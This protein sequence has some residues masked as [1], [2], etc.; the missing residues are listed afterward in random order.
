M[1]QQVLLDNDRLNQHT[2]EGL[3]GSQLSTITTREMIDQGFASDIKIKCIILRYSEA[4]RKLF[5]KSVK[6][7]KTGRSRKKTYQEE[8][9]YIIDHE[10]RSSF[11]KNLVL[12]LKGNKLVFFRIIKHGEKIYESLANN[13]NVFLYCG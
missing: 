4:E 8:V 6:D 7:V 13:S 1:V 2:I 11:I 10:K 3:F 9:D 12:S 5:N